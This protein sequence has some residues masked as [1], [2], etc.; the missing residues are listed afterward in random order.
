MNE[1]IKKI[2][3]TNRIYPL[4]ITSEKIVFAT[5]NINNQDLKEKIEFLFDKEVQFVNKDEN[6]I[7]KLLKEKY[8]NISIGIGQTSLLDS[9]FFMDKMPTEVVS[10]ILEKAVF[11]RASDIHFEPTENLL[12]TRVRIDGILQPGPDIQIDILPA[13]LSH[14]KIISGLDISEKRRPQDGK[15]SF[16]YNKRKIDVR[17]STI[18]TTY[19]EKIV[20]RLLDS[21]SL[22]LGLNELGF[23]PGQEQIFSTNINAKQGIILITGPTGSGKTTTLYSALNYLNDPG[24]NIVTVEDPVEY[25]LSGLIQTQVQPKIGYNFANALR[26]FLRQDTDII[27]VGEIRDRETA[28]I[29]IRASLTGHL[30]FSTLHTNS[31]MDTFSRL[32]DMGIPSYLI[33]DTIKMVVAQR[34][35]RRICPACNNGAE[36]DNCPKCRS[37]GYYGRIGAFEVLPITAEIQ[38]MIKENCSKKEFKSIIKKQKLM[39]FAESIEHYIKKGLTSE[40]EVQRVFFQE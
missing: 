34:L 8:G 7:L 39:A 17:V 38:T 13:V 29:A 31:T 20:L 16:Y 1:K 4:E 11:L 25:E 27:F 30:V 36:K 28:E 12:R 3:L 2:S 23:L 19:R 37:T 18:P 24:I 22:Q 35:L 14:I 26:A 10:E 5:E 6:D 40:E 15:F 21:E 32:M 9:R 33:S